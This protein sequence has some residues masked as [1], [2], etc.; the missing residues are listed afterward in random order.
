MKQFT[1]TFKLQLDRRF[2]QTIRYKRA[3]FVRIKGGAS[4]YLYET[5]VG[6]WTTS[7]KEH[8]RYP[9][10]IE[11]LV[12]AFVEHYYRHQLRDYEQCRSKEQ[13]WNVRVR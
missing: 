3:W 7:Y 6:E 11:T 12:E 2:K 8:M 1:I 10:K 5:N 9:N 4:F 13:T